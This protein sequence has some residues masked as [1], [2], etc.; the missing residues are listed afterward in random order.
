MSNKDVA[1]EAVTGS[2]K[3]LAFVIPILEIL[4]KREEK[5]KNLQ[6]G[7]LIITPTRELAIQIDEVIRQ[8]LVHFPQFSQILFIGGNNPIEDVEKFKKQGGN[9]VVG[10]PGRLEDL[11]RRRSDGLD[12]A[13][14]VKTLEVLV[15]DEAD[16]LLEMGFE[17]ST[18]VEYQLQ[19]GIQMHNILTQ[20]TLGSALVVDGDIMGSLFFLF[21]DWLDLMGQQS[22]D[23]ILWLWVLLL[24]MLFVMQEVL[25][26]SLTR[27]APHFQVCLVL[28]PARPP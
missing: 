4:L 18:E 25:F 19:S 2:G 28:L 11:F 15:L 26:V 13:G 27:L 5:L 1:A 23:Q 22:L 9:I 16:R 8:F 6:V 10:T 24:L 14:C 3:T 21:I 20:S 12:L 17:A 7:A